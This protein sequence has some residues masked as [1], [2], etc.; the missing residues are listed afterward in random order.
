MFAQKYLAYYEENPQYKTVVGRDALI[1]CRIRGR[2]LSGIA[3]QMA[4][5]IE[6]YQLLDTAKW[7][8]FVDIFATGNVDSANNGWRGEYWGKL[9]RGACIT[10]RYTQNEQL[11]AVLTQTVRDMLK[12]QD[13][14]GRFATYAVE[15]EY[16]GWDI[17]SRKYIILGML[18]YHE[19]CKDAQLKEQIVKALEAHL[20]YMVATIGEG[21][22]C[23]NET[24]G[25]WGAANSVSLLEPVMRMYNQTGK[26]SYLE[27][28]NYIV[29][30][31][32]KLVHIFEVA[33]E[34]EM[35]PYQWPIQ[36]AYE[37]MSCFEGLLEYY[38]ATGEEKWKAAAINFADRIIET[39]VTLIGCC[40]CDVECL[41][42]SAATQTNPNFGH[43][44]QETCVTVTWM[45]LC[46]QLLCLTGDVK[47]AEEIERS[48]YN[49]L[50]GA[51]NTDKTQVNG[52]WP[53]DSYSPLRLGN[54]G[55]CVGGQQYDDQKRLIYGCCIAIGAAGTGIVPEIAASATADGVVFNLYVGG[56]YR[57][58]TPQ[59][60][61]LTVKVATNY[62]VDGR[63]EFELLPEKAQEFAV[64][65]RVPS[66]SQ[67]TKLTV[68]GEACAANTGYVTLQRCW[69]AGD[70][71][72]LE[73]D[74]CPRVVHPM[75][76]GVPGSTDFIAVKYGPV[77]LARDVRNN[78]DAGQ[79]VD[80]AY[81]EN[82]RIDIIPTT[83]APFA[84]MCEFKVP[85]KDGSFIHM[86]D[87]QSA[88]KTWDD[89]SA[90]E[91]WLPTA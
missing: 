52:G 29:K 40:G 34:N 65:L 33:F 22:V 69:N 53:F 68:N 28:A 5:F 50:Y 80:L 8:Q 76:C 62:P 49:A 59:N 87:Y 43:L 35:A 26:T 14:L 77:V 46:Y 55:R 63:V 79:K 18:H 11:Y 17:W 81:D 3:D 73:L 32:P 67:N 25:I 37:L 27:F 10:Y 66:F 30:T 89:A 90:T 21:K 61:E 6:D 4:R 78:P 39:D 9:M 12:T 86:V 56:T 84:T 45:K 47:Y 20:D 58:V 60:D 51:V 7:K 31:G 70:K 88:G 85:C 13:D 54:R 74:M 71:I 75:G 41:D 15:T 48:V 24:S 16:N 91:A 82:D 1:P 72:V 38:R 2:E 23:I 64:R 19:I 57:L 83:G 36:K 44:M 42:H